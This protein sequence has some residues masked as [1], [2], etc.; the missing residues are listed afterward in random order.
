MADATIP[1]IRAAIKTQLQTLVSATPSN[2]QLLTVG[3][4][5]GEITRARPIDLDVIGTTP[6]ALVAAAR[7]TFDHT[8]STTGETLLL[9]DTRWVVFLVVSDPQHPADQVTRMDA[10]LEATLGVL[11]GLTV[12]NAWG[13]SMLQLLDWTPFR[14][15][16][17]VVVYAITLQCVRHLDTETNRAVGAADT[18]AFASFEGGINLVNTDETEEP[19]A[20]PAARVG[21]NP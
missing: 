20:N 9:G 18:D 8:P 17:G 10:L 13:T 1:T 15:E 21:G 14:V 2:S 7:E 5:L 6:A 12:A 19:A 4:W 3:D 16:R 11:A